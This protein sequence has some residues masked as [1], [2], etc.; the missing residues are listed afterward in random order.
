M[1][2]CVYFEAK[3]S[4]TIW[5]YGMVCP[6]VRLPNE[7]I[8]GVHSSVSDGTVNCCQTSSRRCRRRGAKLLTDSG[9]VSQCWR[10]KGSHCD[11]LAVRFSSSA[12]FLATIWRRTEI[13]RSLVTTGALLGVVYAMA[14]CLCASVYVS[15]CLSV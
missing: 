9:V 14:L 6:A 4:L 1:H 3:S 10:S 5:P 8:T 13:L 2:L 12:N 7:F 11:F 15:V